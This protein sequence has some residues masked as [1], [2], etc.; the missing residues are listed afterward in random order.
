M[1][2]WGI[3]F[4]L[5][6]MPVVYA[7]QLKVGIPDLENASKRRLMSEID[8]IYPGKLIVSELPNQRSIQNV[9]NGKQDF[10]YPVLLPLSNVKRS[11]DYSFS[12]VTIRRI[13]YAVYLNKA[14]KEIGIH[15]LENYLIEGERGHVEFFD[16]DVVP[17]TCVECSFKKLENS[18]IDG[19][20][21]PALEGDVLIKKLG[22]RNIDSLYFDTY[23]SKF[24]LPKNSR[25]EELNTLL[26]SIISKMKIS[27]RYLILNK[28]NK[29]WKPSRQQ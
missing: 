11:F 17:S 9:V 6:L 14:N 2:V 16:F 8:E 3:I 12:K 22:L 25:G 27:E 29:T 15:N 18:R 5:V 28:A 7:Q 13:V 23:E 4:L 24:A 10:H 21:Y 20:I 19:F 26:S 1:N